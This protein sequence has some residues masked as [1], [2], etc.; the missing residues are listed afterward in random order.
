MSLS[1]V[2]LFT[3]R[4]TLWEMLIEK[5]KQGI[6]HRFFC[7]ASRFYRNPIT[8][9]HF[10][11]LR[12]SGVGLARQPS[13]FRCAPATQNYY[14]NIMMCSC[15]WF[16]IEFAWAISRAAAAAAGLLLTGGCVWSHWWREQH[17]KSPH[18]ARRP[19]TPLHPCPFCALMFLIIELPPASFI[20]C[21]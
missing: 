21:R 3:Q 10:R 6:S 11:E 14:N 12:K 19:P 15:C 17:N 8:A 16:I 18:P 20:C 7:A 5:S 9:D 1:G 2:P 13:S 4:Q